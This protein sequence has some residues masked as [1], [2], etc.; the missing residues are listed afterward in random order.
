MTQDIR[1]PTQLESNLML[2]ELA[3][4]MKRVV[5][6]YERRNDGMDPHAKANMIGYLKSEAG[7][8]ISLVM[9]EK[10]WM[11]AEV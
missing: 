5:E 1:K 8:I 11:D 6:S 2:R 7:N 3:E 4:R 9:R 10:R